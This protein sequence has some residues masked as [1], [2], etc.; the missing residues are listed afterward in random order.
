M[1]QEYPKPFS[2]E[3]SE[4]QEIKDFFDCVMPG[5]VKFLSDH[6]LVGDSY[7][8]VWSVRELSLIHIFHPVGLN[9]SNYREQRTEVDLHEEKGLYLRAAG[10]AGERESPKRRPLHRVCLENGRGADHDAFLR[11]VFE[12]S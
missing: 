2:R 8:C 9:G 10:R 7:R 12:R 1:N 5:T 4:R 3:K 11:A 6:Y